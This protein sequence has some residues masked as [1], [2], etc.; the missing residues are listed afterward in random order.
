MQK[1]SRTKIPLFIYGLIELVELI[2]SITF[3][4]IFDRFC[5]CP[6]YFQDFSSKNGYKCDT[7]DQ[8]DEL[9]KMIIVFGPSF[10]LLLNLFS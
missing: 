6:S 8:L 7:R 3:L 10:I 2:T 9:Y 5:R 1:S 4:S